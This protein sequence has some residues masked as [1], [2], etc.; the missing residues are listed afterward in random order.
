M[1]FDINKFRKDIAAKRLKLDSTE[2]AISLRDAAKEANTSPATLSRL[3]R[4][5]PP[6]IFTFGAICGWLGK[7]PSDYFINDSSI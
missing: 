3:E 2:E 4:G 1:T 7:S 5:N 6:D